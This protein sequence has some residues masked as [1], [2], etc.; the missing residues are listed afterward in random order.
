MDLSDHISEYCSSE[1]YMLLDAAVKAHAE[2]ILHEW[3]GKATA[4]VS[5][6]SVE[7]ALNRMAR[8]NLP[9]DARRAIPSLIKDYCNY[10]I[11]T[12]RNPAVQP[13]IDTIDLLN[14]T[15]Q[16]QFRDDGSV[17]G[18]TFKKKYTDVNRND[19]CPCGSGK[20]FKKCCLGIV[21]G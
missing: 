7:M 20:K 18:E 17:R 15:Y 9:V 14:N 19:P 2:P 10:L 5:I 3:A 13:W 1:Y 6:D 16:N 8:L 12:G 4:T 11:S 21:G